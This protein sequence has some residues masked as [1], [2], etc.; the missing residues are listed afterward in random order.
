MFSSRDPWHVFPVLLLERF[1]FVCDSSRSVTAAAKGCCARISSARHLRCEAAC[2]G[3]AGTA[4]V[5][6]M[7]VFFCAVVSPPLLC[8]TFS[9]ANRQHDRHLGRSIMSDR[10]GQ[11]VASYHLMRLLEQ[12]SIIDRYLASDLTTQ[13]QVTLL[14]LAS[15]TDEP[16]NLRFQRN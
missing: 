4:E 13:R 14:L 1:C 16:G 15:Q 11:H 12:G 8:Y 5:G 3:T 6:R 9:V 2:C 10:T 7:T